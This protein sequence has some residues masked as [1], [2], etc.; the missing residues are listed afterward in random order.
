MAHIR[1]S[2]PDYSFVVQVRVLTLLESV[3]SLLGSET[4]RKVGGVVGVATGRG[5]LS[6]KHGTCK[7]VKARFWHWR[8]GSGLE[9]FNTDPSSLGSGLQEI[10][11][12]VGGAH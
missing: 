11:Q 9:N 8:S 12:G 2:T 5:P 7:T 3:P 6:S 4:A 10:S 1:Q